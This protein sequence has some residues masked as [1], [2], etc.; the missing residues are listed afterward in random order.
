VDAA[1]PTSTIKCNNAACSTGWYLAPV[2]VSLSATDNTGGSGVS[3]TYYTTDGSTPTTSSTRYT[4]AFSVPST[5]TVKYFS[6]DTA[7]GAEA[8]KSQLIQIDGT[9][10]TTT[11]SC[12][13]VACSTSTYPAAVTVSLSRA[14]NTGGSGVAST[15]YTTN[16]TAPT[17][18]S[19][20]YTAPFTVPASATV[21][22]RSWDTAGNVEAT[23]TQTITVANLVGNPGFE[24][25][26]TGWAPSG[27]SVTLARVSGGHSGSWSGRIS[28]S[29]LLPRT[30]ILDDSPNWVIKT[31]A[32][33]YT[34]SL[35]VR[36]ASA[37]ATMNLR[38][39]EM[40]GATIVSSATSTLVLS[41]AWQQITVSRA[42]LQP[43]VTTLN[44][45]A[46]VTNVGLLGTAFFADDAAIALG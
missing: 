10:P 6:V 17:L 25:N 20:T 23:K 30:C 45:N 19:P 15:H 41:T 8:V 4:A 3:G 21:S 24:T 16:G 39:Q 35:W 12:N 9:P 44:L 37:G 7:G 14:D 42:I 5:A 34:A 1:P 38:L 40:N 32:G 11:I 36:G 46:Y 33:A 29:G 2:Q 18:T 13:N 28:N 22:F 31:S 26:T 43:G 27:T